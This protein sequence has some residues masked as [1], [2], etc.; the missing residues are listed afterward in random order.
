MEEDNTS[1]LGNV[2]HID[3]ERIQDHLGRIVRG[4][5]EKTLN[6]LLDAEADRLNNSSRWNA[7]KAVRMAVRYPMNASCIPRQGKWP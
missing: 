5:V 3:D 4:S 1:S 6:A 7:R 2:I